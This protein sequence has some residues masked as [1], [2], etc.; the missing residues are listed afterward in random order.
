MK[1]MG[2]SPAGE[3]A[4]LFIIMIL[5]LAFVLTVKFRPVGCYLD[6]PDSNGNR[7]IMQGNAR[8]TVAPGLR[9][10]TERDGSR[11]EVYVGP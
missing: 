7:I 2:N 10:R 5:G 4:W 3:F 8:V 9:V 1:G 11:A 6:I